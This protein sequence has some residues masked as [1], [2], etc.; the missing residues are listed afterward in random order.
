M[1]I[2][3]QQ[4]VT[5]KCTLCSRVAP[6][7]QVEFICQKQMGSKDILPGGSSGLEGKYRIAYQ[8]A[9]G[10]GFVCLNCQRKDTRRSF[11]F[12][13]VVLC[14]AAL[15]LGYG[16]WASYRSDASDWVPLFFIV[17]FGA[18]CGELFLWP[19]SI[20]RLQKGVTP[21]SRLLELIQPKVFP[22]F[23]AQGYS[24]YGSP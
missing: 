7:R 6:C 1:T 20:Y 13:T 3:K 4:L 17:G 23:K 18:V 15:M 10:T 14:L 24:R 9:G 19:R 12:H 21:D 11:V 5:M 22:A 2:E 16:Q 8:Q